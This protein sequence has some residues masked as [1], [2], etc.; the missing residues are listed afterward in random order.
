ML[1][2]RTIAL[3][4]ALSLPMMA[5]AA[6]GDAA[7]GKAK[8]AVCAGCHGA[9]GIAIS[10]MYPNLKGQ[11]KMYLKSSLKAFKN[12]SRTGGQAMMMYAMAANLSDADIA[13][14]AAYYSSLK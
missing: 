9:D 8:A 14:L 13:D 10:P 2:K 3:A 5:N 12:K 6:K 1:K 11:K 4:L 7:A